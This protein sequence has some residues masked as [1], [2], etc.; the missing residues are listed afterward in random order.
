MQFQPLVVSEE[1]LQEL[2]LQICA[3]RQLKGISNLFS[4]SVQQQ[5]GASAIAFFCLFI[6]AIFR[7]EM[8]GF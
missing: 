5:T 4:G 7:G 8:E 1:R 6:F 3:P 2:H